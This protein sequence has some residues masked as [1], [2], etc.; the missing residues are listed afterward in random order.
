MKQ[1]EEIEQMLISEIHSNIDKIEILECNL[2]HYNEILGDT[3]FLLASIL[4]SLLNSNEDWDSKKWIDDSLLTE[5]KLDGN[6]LSIW[7]IMIWG[8]EN[9]TEQ[10]TDPF[11]FEIKLKQNTLGFNEYTF[12]FCDLDKSEISYEDFSMNRNYWNPTER[13]WKYIINQKNPPL[14]LACN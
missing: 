1:L 9:T 2:E 4:N 3:S 6:K 13:N 11:Y 10:W 8:I 14:L 7:G 12:L 5:V